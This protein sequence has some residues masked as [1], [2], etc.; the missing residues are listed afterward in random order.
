M[1]IYCFTT[2]LDV[3][4]LGEQTNELLQMKGAAVCYMNI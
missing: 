4:K 2:S 3:C 1:A